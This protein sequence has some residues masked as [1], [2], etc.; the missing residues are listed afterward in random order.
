ME[1]HSKPRTKGTRQIDVIKMAFDLLKYSEEDRGK[2]SGRK[3]YPNGSS[4]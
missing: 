3:N 4:S 2:D 1:S